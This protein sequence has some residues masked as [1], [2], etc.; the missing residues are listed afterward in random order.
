MFYHLKE[1]YD[2]PSEIA[3][4]YQLLDDLGWEAIN[5]A[6]LQEWQKTAADY[7][8]HIPDNNVKITKPAG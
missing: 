7:A 6:T 3:P 1:G 5:N 4:E 8:M 2:G